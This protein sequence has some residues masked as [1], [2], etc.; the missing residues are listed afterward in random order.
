MLPVM[1]F[2]CF[3]EASS[4]VGKVNGSLTAAAAYP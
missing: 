2:L 3:V 4:A 1:E